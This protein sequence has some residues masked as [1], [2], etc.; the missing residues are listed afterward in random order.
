MKRHQRGH[1]YEAFNAFHV[2]YYTTEGGQRKQK[3]HRL[4]T[5]DR[6][7]GHASTNSKAVRELCEDFM[8]DINAEVPTNNTSLTVVEFWDKVYLPFITGNLK[9]STVDGYQQVWGQHLKQHFGTT[10]LR[11]YKTPMGSMFLTSLAK[12]YRP[13]TLQHI[14]FLASG[15]FMH[16]VNTGNVDF[17]PWRDCRVLGKQLEN[18]ETEAYTL[19]EAEQIINALVDHV[20]C[21]LMMALCFFCGLRKGEIQG[22][23]WGDF[24]DHFVI[25]QRAVVRGVVGTLKGKKKVRRVP[26]IAPVKLL[27]GLCRQKRNGSEWVFPSERGT[28]LDLNEVAQRTIR[29]VLRKAGLPWRGYHAGRRGLG[30]ELRAITGNSNAG[31]DLLG[32]TDER[33]TQDHYEAAMPEEVLKGMKLLEAKVTKGA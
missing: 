23:Q 17:N 27:L 31:R 21:Q 26:L 2:R 12:T 20:H 18:S 8:R 19:T 10:L 14:K 9:P 30:T 13:R 5:K 7:T 6:A 15:L 3:S 33:V 28:P 11:D 24:E 29:P 1:I 32:H 4:C 22:L 16:A 25:V